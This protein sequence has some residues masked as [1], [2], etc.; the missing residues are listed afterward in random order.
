MI[1]FLA[2]NV[3]MPD[4]PYEKISNWISKV[5]AAHNKSIGQICYC[6]CDDDYILQINNQFLN[7]DYFTDIITFDY[8][9]KSRISGDILISLN[10][11][12]SNAE[13]LN[14]PFPTELLRVIIHGILHL[15]GID[16]KGDGQRQIM[17]QHENAALELFSL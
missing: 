15:C 9:K 17:E 5:A 6:F 1:D 7:H 16:D 11:V 10:T 8:T 13:K 12:A 3:H 14:Q 4:L 2:K